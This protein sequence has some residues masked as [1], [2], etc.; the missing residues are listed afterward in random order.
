MQ[1]ANEVVVPSPPAPAAQPA[2]PGVAAACAQL[3]PTASTAP[4]VSLPIAIA[5]PITTMP[6]VPSAPP[7]S[8]APAAPQAAA[9]ATV[10]ALPVTTAVPIT[11]R[12]SSGDPVANLPVVPV[13]PVVPVAPAGPS[14]PAAPPTTAAAPTTCDL[15]A[16]AL[17]GPLVTGARPS[18]LPPAVTSATPVG[19]GAT[20]VP[21]CARRSARRPPSLMSVAERAAY[22]ARWGDAM[23]KGFDT[24]ARAFVEQQPA[25]QP[26][27]E[28]TGAASA[29]GDDA[30]ITVASLLV[31]SALGECM[32][33]VTFETLLA[34]A[35]T[36]Q[37]ASIAA[38]LDAEEWRQEQRSCAADEAIAHALHAEENAAVGGYAV[39][40]KRSSHFSPQ[41]A[42]SGALRSPTKRG[43]NLFA[44]GAANGALPIQG[45][46]M[47]THVP[48]AAVASAPADLAAI[49]PIAVIPSLTP[50]P[51]PPPP[52]PPPPASRPP[53]S[54]Q[55]SAVAPALSGPLVSGA[56]AQ[57]LGQPP[58]G[59]SCSSPTATRTA[60]TT[61]PGTGQVE[62]SCSRVAELEELLEASNTARTQLEAALA[63]TESSLSA[64]QLEVE[65]VQM[66]GA[67]VDAW[68]VSSDGSRPSE[69][70]GAEDRAAFEAAG[71]GVTTAA[72][73]TTAN[74]F[75][76]MMRA[77]AEREVEDAREA[78]VRK[79]KRDARAARR[80]AVESLHLP[81]ELQPSWSTV[82]WSES[83]FLE[84]EQ[85]TQER[86][87]KPIDTSA[88]APK[89]SKP[90]KG[91][92]GWRHNSRQGL[93]GGVRYWANGSRDNVVTMLLGLI[94]DFGVADAI[95]HR[96]FQK[97]RREVETDKMI[98]DRLVAALE[99][100]KGCQTEQQ[101]RDY[102][103]ALSLVTPPRA[104]ERDCKGFARR[105]AARLR[106]SRGKRSK[107]RGE[108]PYAFETATQHRE[109]FDKAAGRYRL[110]MATLRK[111][112]QRAL[113]ADPLEVGEKVLTHNGPAELVRFTEDG[114]CVVVYRVGDDFA[115][116]KYTEC[117][118]LA[119][120]S[121]RL[122]R[123]PPSLTPPPRATSSL[124]ISDGTRKL[125]LDHFK[126]RCPTSPHQRDVM[127]RRIGPFVVQEKVSPHAP[128]NPCCAGCGCASPCCPTD[129][130]N[131]LVGPVRG[132]PII[133]LLPPNLSAAG[134]PRGAFTTDASLTEA[135]LATLHPSADV[136]IAVVS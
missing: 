71:S 83:T 70:E 47:D 5:F 75:G 23:A 111:G 112:Q 88:D 131:T 113:V 82:D 34:A 134:V 59:R 96:L 79:A 72:T 26:V 12:S 52:P 61:P 35:T 77:R 50:P 36:D 49:V 91:R 102:L 93:A 97:A 123:M 76:R 103:L 8:L 89:V 20:A 90:R 21:S 25:L 67:A 116:R 109:T 19:N 48:A 108:R 37:V 87:R 92:H 33:G 119:K 13:T 54:P 120:G 51:A 126:A 94:D 9:M 135:T 69:A 45:D 118:S 4:P 105:V 30:T 41:G 57:P 7:A 55:P 24:T 6:H 104:D 136:V 73:A 42:P 17:S 40:R 130:P 28:H 66:G 29:V 46:E 106:V 129:A 64:A 110:S 100:L 43:R 63:D 39:A 3:M 133:K 127:R 107:K 44:I 99:V 81:T 11:T 125:I 80:Q 2:P 56:S 86:R 128:S 68:S 58:D 14:P 78:E 1:V 132:P 18:A 117:Y 122:R 15:P 53:P 27:S 124:S 31:G 101:R 121:A 22:D 85:K 16:G 74:A 98:V 65:R 10:A 32:P 114:G 115:E 84:A 62:R 60:A 38:D 95:R